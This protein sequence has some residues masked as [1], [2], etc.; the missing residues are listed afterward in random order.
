VA[1]F[2]RFCELEDEGGYKLIERVGVELGICLLGD[3]P[4]PGAIYLVPGR[5]LTAESVPTLRQVTRLALAAYAHCLLYPPFVPE[6]LAPLLGCAGTF[7]ISKGSGAMVHLQAEWETELP[8]PLHI[9]YSGAIQTSYLSGLIAVGEKEEPVL[10]SYRPSNNQGQV[11]VTT[12]LVASPNI[13]TREA[14]RRALLKAVLDHL[15]A[16]QPPTKPRK[17]SEEKITVPREVLNTT[18][19]ALYCGTAT[20]PLSVVDFA[21]NRLG[22]RID[23]EMVANAME[24]LKLEGVLAVDSIPNEEQ[25]RG[26]IVAHNLDSLARMLHDER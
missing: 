18:A 16:D 20:S 4:K 3:A 1:Q 13:R 12:L 15:A 25:L 8:T 14:H 2:L 21:H 24:Q 10:L 23:E 22:A 17:T 7:R 5:S 26:F 19:L 9:A 11:M 6:D